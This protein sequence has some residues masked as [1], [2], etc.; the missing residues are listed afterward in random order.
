MTMKSALASL[1][2][3]GLALSALSLPNASRAETVTLAPADDPPIAA[4][5]A[6]EQL[7][8]AD[9]I[10]GGGRD[11]PEGRGL[12][13]RLRPSVISLAGHDCSPPRSMSG[14]VSIPPN[15]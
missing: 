8:E 6:P 15:R 7:R 4:R 14:S 9:S 1:A 11:S 13:G 10:S 5:P 2:L 12:P 3:A